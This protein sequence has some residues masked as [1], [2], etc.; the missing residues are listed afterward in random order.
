MRIAVISDIHGNIGAF[1][2][3]LSDLDR[4]SVDQ[5]VSLGDNV[6]YGADPEAVVH[7]L[8]QRNIL[9]VMGN[10]EL[11]C[12]R[13]KVYRWYTGDVKS[14]LDYTLSRLSDASLGFLEQWPLSLSRNNAYFVHGFWPDS[15]RHYLH[16]ISP[17]ELAGTFTK[18]KETCCFIGHTHQLK[19]YFPDP[20]GVCAEQ[21]D[22]GITKLRQ[23]LTYMIN[24]GSVGQPR[25]G[26]LR[27]G[28]LIWDKRKH[29]LEVRRVMYDHAEAAARIKNA[30]LP[31]KYAQ[32]VCP[33][34]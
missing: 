22:T 27:A 19:L 18:I 6:G 7:R 21:L 31:L 24:A 4:M 23:G 25:D 2:A 17:S 16:Q 12:V 30:G 28:Y 32:A 8:L 10:H 26:D 3:V 29:H 20:A 1:D 15:V 14:A 34:V 9:S 13:K 11:A 33:D 5:I